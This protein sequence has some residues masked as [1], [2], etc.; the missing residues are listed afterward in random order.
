MRTFALALVGLLVLGSTAIAQNNNRNGFTP[1]EMDRPLSTWSAGE[2]EAPGT[3]S[4]FDPPAPEPEDPPSGGPTFLGETLDGDNFVFV[5]DKSGSMGARMS[6]PAG[7]EIT[8]QNGNL[9]SNPSRWQ[10]IQSEAS[11]A[12]R[13]MTEDDTFDLVLFT[14]RYV[15]CFNSLTM[16]DGSGKSTGLSFMYRH[17]AG[18]GTG[19]N[20]PLSHAFS[21]GG[22]E[23]M[24]T[25]VFMT[26]GYPFDGAQT[27]RNY[28]GWVNGQKAAVDDFKTKA[29]QIGGGGLNSFMSWLA[30]QNYTTVTLK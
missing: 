7:T 30:G 29:Y 1:Q 27:Q 2:A 9:I 19:F 24:D 13:Q 6:A 15:V 5:L 23:A 26:D 10:V 12:I 18:G 21:H 8:D 14:T 17:R 25:C 16:A 4:E 28:P 20:G 11:N 3:N 22:Y